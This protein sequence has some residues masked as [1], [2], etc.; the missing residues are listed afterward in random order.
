MDRLFLCRP[1]IEKMPAY[2]TVD[3]VE[4]LS[5]RKVKGSCEL[6]G[7]RRFGY[8]CNVVFAEATHSIIDLDISAYPQ[9][10]RF[11]RYERRVTK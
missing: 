1:C 4:P 7:C 3:K 9:F 6:C 2:Q 10:K 11:P 8:D 5:S